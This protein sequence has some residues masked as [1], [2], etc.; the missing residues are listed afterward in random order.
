MRG[1]ASVQKNLRKIGTRNIALSIITHA[2]IYAGAKKAQIQPLKHFRYAICPQKSPK[3]L[4][5]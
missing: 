3:S 4:T 1:N 5:V 2:E